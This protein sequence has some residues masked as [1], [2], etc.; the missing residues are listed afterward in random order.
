VA[1]ISILSI[2][3]T[4]ANFH[5]EDGLASEAVLDGNVEIR[6][7][8]TVR[9]LNSGKESAIAGSTIELKRFPAEEVRRIRSLP[10]AEANCKILTMMLKAMKVDIRDTRP[11]RNTASR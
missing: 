6:F 1:S 2:R 3:G 11:K 9:E 5:F 8:A 4:N 10:V 7:H